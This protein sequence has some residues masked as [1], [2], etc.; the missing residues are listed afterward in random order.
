MNVRFPL[1]AALLAATVTLAGCQSSNPMTT[2]KNE[3]WSHYGE[4]VRPQGDVV[5][6]GALGGGE[7]QVIV[8][9]TITEIC[10]TKGCWMKIHDDEG[11]ELFVKFKDYSFFMPRNA[12]GRRVVLHGWAEMVEASV[13]ELRHYA[14]DAGQSAEEI[15]MI[16]EPEQR[17]TFHADSVY[18]QGRGLDAPH[19]Q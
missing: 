3:G 18:I 8:T 10:Q 19:V 4:Q 5:S 11:N 16:T 9:G 2:A 12:S 13:D 7:T 17:V 15:A 1:C 14:E 6:L